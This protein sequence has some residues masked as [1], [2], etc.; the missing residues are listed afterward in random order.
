MHKFVWVFLALFLCQVDSVINNS[1]EFSIALKQNNIDTL[2]KK[3]LDI[4]YA[5]SINYGKFWSIV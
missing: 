1:I 5:L 2:K 3:L 4:S